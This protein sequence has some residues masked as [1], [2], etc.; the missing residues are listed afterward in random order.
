MIAIACVISCERDYFSRFPE[1]L[2]VDSTAKTNN[3]RRP[4]LIVAGKD[5]NDKMFTI[6]GAFIPNERA[7]S[8]RSNRI[9]CL[10]VIQEF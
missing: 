8:L 9:G 4:L 3:E 7:W 6:L 10:V 1:V 2:F 5:A